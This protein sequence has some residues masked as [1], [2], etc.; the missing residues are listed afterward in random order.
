MSCRGWPRD[1]EV[2]TSK[3]EI[4][5]KLPSRRHGHAP[6]HLRSRLI[7]AGS[8]LLAAYSSKTILP[9]GL[10]PPDSPF[11]ATVVIMFVSNHQSLIKAC[12]PLD[13]SGDPLSSPISNPLGKLTFYAAGR[14]KKLPKVAAVL[15]ERA[16]R[17]GRPSS[18]PKGR[19][20]LAV[21]VEIM[22]ELVSECR[23]ELRCFADQALRVVE[24]GLT[25]REGQQRDTQLEAR[26]ASLVSGS[27]P[28]RSRCLGAD[29]PV[30]FACCSSTPY[31][32]SPRVPSS[33]STTHSENN[34]CVASRSSPLWPSSVLTRLCEWLSQ[35]SRRWATNVDYVQLA[36]HRARRDQG[37]RRFRAA[38]L[39][40]I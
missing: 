24:L 14:P 8:C 2:E 25:R 23:T 7:P 32:P 18:G 10:S 9:G 31:R 29:P 37:R 40:S 12:Y 34:T 20:G 11:P 38:L 21:T 17:D 4:S 30:W 28:E 5:S 27:R 1:G 39:A 16:E 15:L 36:L 19:A 3:R 33:A 13:L 6:A 35:T 22:K 26:A